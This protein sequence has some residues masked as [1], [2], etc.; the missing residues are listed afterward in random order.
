MDNSLIPKSAVEAI[1]ATI[2]SPSELAEKLDNLLGELTASNPTSARG[3]PISDSEMAF[4]RIDA[5][6]SY[7]LALR[8]TVVTGDRN[9]MFDRISAGVAACR[10]ASYHQVAR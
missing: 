9:A 4:R 2:P 3:M 10:T 6:N 5:L 7:L 8:L 1:A